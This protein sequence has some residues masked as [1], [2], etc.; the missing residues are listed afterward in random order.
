MATHKPVIDVPC[1][2]CSHNQ[3]QHE[4][5][6][7]PSIDQIGLQYCSGC[8]NS[9]GEES[10]F[11]DFSPDNLKYLELEYERKEQR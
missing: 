6:V 9:L 4:D 8:Y 3:S 2:L 1:K 5:L 7:N 10:C 11:H